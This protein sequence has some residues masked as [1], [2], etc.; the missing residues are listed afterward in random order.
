MIVQA[1][2][3]LQ[4]QLVSIVVATYNGER[5]LREQLDSIVNQTYPNLEIVIVDDAS[6]DGTIAILERYAASYPNICVYKAEKNL[7]YIKNFQKG[8]LLCKGDY[9]ALS[10]QDDIWLPEKISILMKEKGEHAMVYCNSELIGADGESLG[11]KLTDLKNLLDFWTPLNYVVG[12][13]ASGHAMLVKREV[14]EQSLPLPVI[15]THDYWIGFVSTLFSPI[16]FVDEVLVLYRQHGGNVIGV[17]SGGTKATRKKK[18]TKESRNEI[19]RERMKMMYEKC[20]DSLP[21]IKKVFYSLH[22][23]YQNFS[24]RH[25]F[26]RMIIF[27]RYRKE[28]TAYKKRKELR[29]WLFCMKMFFKIE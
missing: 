8:L 21:E 9:I 12:G 2:E 16:K 7:G 17:N 14:I 13:T 26:T 18:I 20:P 6:N 1:K 19:I 27:F 15:V 11:I 28:I 29:R 4:L 5:F 3:S 24:L 10:D 23:S 25:N 22:K